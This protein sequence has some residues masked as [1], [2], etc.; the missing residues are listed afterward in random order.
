MI[1]GS[2]T[3]AVTANMGGSWRLRTEL[4]RKNSNVQY[5]PYRVVA[6]VEDAAASASSMQLPACTHGERVCAPN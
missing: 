6:V 4:K 3:R 2:A 1:E 5:P